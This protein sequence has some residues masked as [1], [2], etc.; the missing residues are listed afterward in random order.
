VPA[1]RLAT[2]G[3][4]PA[5]ETLLHSGALPTADLASAKPR[6]LVAFEGDSLIGVAGLEGFGEVALVRSVAVAP[7]HRGRGIGQALVRELERA[8]RSQGATQ[9]I[10]LT[11][12]AER[13]F[14]REGYRVIER[15][16]AP[17]AVQ[18]SAEFRSLCPQS[19][20]CMAKLI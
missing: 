5:I 18:A 8:A 4:L 17:A 15:A 6:F 3:E 14:E 11:E 13:F 9:L 16:T 2:D 20:I 10:L 1:I 19:A 7:S 12:T